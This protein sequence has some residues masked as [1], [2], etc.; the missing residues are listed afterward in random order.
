MSEPSLNVPAPDGATR[1]H[2]I[3]GDPI[4]QVKAPGGV[5]RA[6][7]TRG[8]NALI[9]VGSGTINDLCKHA[10]AQDA[11]P[12]A[13]FATAPSMNG[14]TST[15]AAIT[16]GGH[17]KSLPA[18]AAAGVFCD[19]EVMA[20]APIRLIRAGLGDSLCRCTAQADWLLAH[21]L[22]DQPYREAPF[23]LLA[24]DEP[25]LLAAAEALARREPEAVGHLVRTL[26]LSGFGMTLCGSSAPA[27]QGRRSSKAKPGRASAAQNKP[28]CPARMPSNA[29]GLV[30]ARRLIAR[31]RPAARAPSQSAAAPAA[32]HAT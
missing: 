25:L 21:L 12:Y 26:L 27:S 28:F 10:A 7:A 16:V 31:L 4:A 30:T 23:A 19:L 17:K 32:F 13:V 15:N 5:S 1:L 29:A 3:V 20:A 6:F 22:L 18:R 9:A 2:L 14:Y 11:K 24:E 8:A